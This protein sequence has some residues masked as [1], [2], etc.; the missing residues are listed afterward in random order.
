MGFGYPQPK[1]KPVKGQPAKNQP[2]AKPPKGKPVKDGF[3][4]TE[5]EDMN[6]KK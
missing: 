3:K 5:D 1:G 2:S 4:R 6:E